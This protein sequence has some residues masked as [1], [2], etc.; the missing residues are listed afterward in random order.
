MNFK[1]EILRQLL[2][3]SSAIR[4]QIHKTSSKYI[5]LSA[6][7][8]VKTNNKNKAGTFLVFIYII[9]IQNVPRN[10]KMKKCSLVLAKSFTS[11]V[12]HRAGAYLRFP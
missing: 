7:A 4:I 2:W 1:T 9:K 6:K 12:A 3:P 10:K 8:T 5:V 11:L